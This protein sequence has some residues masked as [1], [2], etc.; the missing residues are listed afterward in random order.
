[1]GPPP[2][3]PGV[4]TRGASPDAPKVGAKRRHPD[5]RQAAI[6]TWA[7]PAVSTNRTSRDE[8]AW[9]L[10]RDGARG[11]SI[12]SKKKPRFLRSVASLP[13]VA[14]RKGRR[15]GTFAECE[16]RS[17]GVAGRRK[18]GRMPPSAP[19]WGPWSAFPA[20]RRGYGGIAHGTEACGWQDA[21]R[22]G[23]R[24]AQLHPRAPGLSEG[25]IL[26]GPR[27]PENRKGH[28]SEEAWPGRPGL[29]GRSAA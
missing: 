26:A 11:E 6:E 18:G 12:R 16:G 25:C 2:R 5:E 14:G 17:A 8:L 3:R 7:P 22:G 13:V 24:P 15:A 4:G 29:S 9:A 27:A 23:R 21:E 10:R 28:A 19:R 1:M 20:A